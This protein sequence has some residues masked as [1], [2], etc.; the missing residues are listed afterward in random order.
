MELE[1]RAKPLGIL[2]CNGKRTGTHVHRHHLNI[3]P[4]QRNG[5]R[6]APAS[7]AD[8]EHTGFVAQA[9]Q[10]QFHQEFG[11]GSGNEDGGVHCERAPKETGVPEDVLQRLP[12]QP[13]R[14]RIPELRALLPREFHLRPSQQ[15]G[16]AQSADFLQN[17]VRLTACALQPGG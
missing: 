4:L 12:V 16:A 5:D 9:L 8:I 14:N 3:G 13:S 15:L 10:S 11:L 2:P 6:D 7:G 1:G 17:P